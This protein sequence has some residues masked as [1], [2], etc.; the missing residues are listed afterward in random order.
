MS[1]FIKDNHVKNLPDVYCKSKDSNNYKLLELERLTLDEYRE[2]L[3]QLFDVLDLENARGQTLDMYGMMAG[4]PRGKATDEQYI[5][6][7]KAKLMQNLSN[8]SHPSIL[9]ALCVTFDSSP[10]EIT[11]VEN[12][13]P[14]KVDVISLP[15]RAIIKSNINTKDTTAMIQQLLPAGVTLTSYLYNGTFTFSDQENEYGE[16]EGFCDVEG[17]MIGGYFGIASGG[18]DII[19]DDMKKGG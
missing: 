15:L 7:I 12:E 10:D 3:Y 18:I 4:Q 11:I 8:G 9:N 17:G 14:C 2:T 5:L 19:T 13:N 16:N 1:E 6:M